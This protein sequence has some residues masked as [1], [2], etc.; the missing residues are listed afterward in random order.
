MKKIIFA[1][2]AAVSLGG[3]V[4]CNDWLNEIPYGTYTLDDYYSDGQACYPVVN[5]CY[6][7]MTWDMGSN[8]Y[9]NEW[10]IGDIASDDAIK[11]GEG[12]SDMSMALDIELFRVNSENTLLL[13]YY[14]AQYAG[15]TRCNRAIAGISKVPADEYM[16]ESE[17]A[18]LI[19]EAKFLRA[20]YHFRL[21]RVFGRVPYVDRVLAGTADMNLPRA[22]YETIYQGI[23]R[24]LTE[25]E[26]ALW[27][28]S[29]YPDKDLGRATKGSAQALLMK[30]YLTGREYLGGGA[31]AFAEA[32]K[33]GQALELSGQY[34][35]CPAY[36]DNFAFT[37][38][39]GPESVFEIQYA[40]DGTSDYGGFGYTRGTFTLVLQRPR[41]SKV[42][43]SPAGWG[44]DRPSQDL[45][46]E[47]ETGDPRMAM[48]VGRLREEDLANKPME[49]Y[50]GKIWTYSHKYSM[51]TDGPG[52]TVYPKPHDSRGPLNH[53]EIRYADVLLMYAEACVETGDLAK[54][55]ALLER[56]RNRARGGNSEILPAFPDYNGYTDNAGDLRRAV[57]H[58]RRVEFA[59]EGK[60]WFDI[61]RWYPLD[62]NGNEVMT[63]S[64]DPE[65]RYIRAVSSIMNAY[66][67]TAEIKDLY[68]DMGQFREGV[69]EIFPIPAEE[70]RIAGLDQNFGY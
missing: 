6:V 18:R 63:A 12:R 51:L 70:R 60:R 31:A 57:R 44:Y 65:K 62:A 21:V 2:L 67:Q 28:K 4:S 5:G 37:G 53:K 29:E 30:V 23:V 42:A 36:W 56:V 19:G 1:V 52:G 68:P 26:A 11:G 41:A 14:S 13:D 50:E 61:V 33:W 27:N 49:V 10:F 69:H 39:N 22:S 54:A 55:K 20:F 34:D 46:D 9:C 64:P 59:M 66:R 16:S 38:E 47:F 40:N 24:D 35:L 15:I 8:T 17:K 25:A 7:P 45:I 58:E 48:T 3:M 32:V 43:G